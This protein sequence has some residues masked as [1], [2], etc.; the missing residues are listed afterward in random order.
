[1]AKKSKTIKAKVVKHR[2]PDLWVV[3]F[4][5]TGG[6]EWWCEGGVFDNLCAAKLVC[7]ASDM[8]GYENML[9]HISREEN[10]D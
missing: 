3:L 6:G 7:N 4:R 10:D 9:V 2:R 1:M 8:N 5:E